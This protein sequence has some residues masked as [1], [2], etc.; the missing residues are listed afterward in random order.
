MSADTLKRY[1]MRD[2]F[3]ID[4]KHWRRGPYR[5]S[6]MVWNIPA[7]EEAIRWRVR[8]RRRA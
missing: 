6:P 1:A 5:N 8:K 3:L 7:C 4:G 2:E